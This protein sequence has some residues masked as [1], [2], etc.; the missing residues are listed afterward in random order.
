MNSLPLGVAPV[1]FGPLQVLLAML[2]A[3]LLSLGSLLFGLLRPRTLWTILRLLWRQKLPVAVAA[4]TIAGLVFLVR[5]V[6][7]GSGAAIQSTE[8]AAADWPLFRG[9]LQRRGSGAGE[10]PTQGGLNWSYTAD[11]RT[12]YA[13]PAV[14]GN[15][16]YITS[17]DK[18]PLRD[19]GAIYCLDA[20]TGGLVWRSAPPGYLATFSSPS[21]AGRFLVCGE[22]LHYTR[23]ARVVCLDVTRN[24]EIV[25][26]YQTRSHVE[27]TPCIDNDRVYVGAGDDGYYCF[28]LE[29]D[30]AG[31]P[32]LIWHVPA[33]KYPDAETSPAVHDG[34]V[35]VGLG[36]EG[37]AVCCLDAETGNELWRV[38]TP[39]P[40]FGPPTVVGGLVV[41]GM[42]N[43][44]FIQSA[45]EV[46]RSEIDKLKKQGKSAEEIA[47]AAKSLGS[48][49]EVWCLGE[50]TG[51]VQWK[52]AAGETILG[53]VAAGEDRFY[54]GSRDGYSYCVSFAGK[55]LAKWNAHA[56][57]VTSPALG[58]ERV[59]AVTETGKLYG[60]R[61]DGLELVW[62]ATVGF[63]GPFLSSPAVARGHVYVGS[64]Q[65]G[66]L[67]LGTPGGRRQEPRWAGLLGG[68]GQGGT[69][70]RQPLPEKGKLAWRFPPTDDAGAAPG[71]QVSAPPACLEGV[72]YV[73]VHGDRNGL[74]CLRD[75]LQGNAPATEL[76]FAH[77]PPGVWLS[78][79]AAAQ[80][81]FFVDGRKGDAD[82]HLNCLATGDGTSRWR[83]PVDANAP[84]DL[85]LLDD[86]GLIA[87]GSERLTCFRGSGE[88]AWHAAC[89]T[90]CG[91]PAWTDAHVVVA[92][93]EPPALLTLDRATGQTLWH[94]PLDAA[95]AAGPVLRGNIIY[96]GSQ[97]GVA[98]FRLADGERLWEAR[99]GRPTTP[100][101]LA[102]EQ[103]AYISDAGELVVVRAEDGRIEKIVRGALPGVPPLAPP[104]SFVY[105]DKNGLRHYPAGS[106][107]ARSW[108]RT[109]WLG[110]LTCPPVMANS[111]VYFGTDKKGLVCLKG[112]DQR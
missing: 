6:S 36:M 101:V 79:A 107:D 98:A 16:V 104:E 88:V 30:P 23:S 57:I 112:K 70:D 46:A 15:R 66:L 73:P 75:D 28:R 7:S 37:R 11:V 5:G 25:W 86:G 12:F 87:D 95:P 51:E 94:L 35:F 47:A 22:G 109:D 99:G 3:L 49:G 61:A 91:M 34:R 9:N 19:R 92:V 96:L 93:D 85:V 105:A 56:P 44:N 62:E 18:G 45:E 72:L 106:D 65:D 17:A 97:A 60:L 111:R 58:G 32:V 33:E 42:G 13:S 4:G 1:L 31:Q 50:R 64:Q 41:V 26:T 76:W 100:L 53:A 40:V 77:S 29:P 52:F 14:V 89:G 55:L 67:C 38:P 43:G 78:P 90:V 20:D 59:Y 80:S 54:F 68:P 10:G 83:L 8:P 2:P 103:L 84:G 48:A 69:I 102:K 63:T 71:L 27:S 39:Y 82:R 108:M 110:R 24:G 74:L 81:V 21:V